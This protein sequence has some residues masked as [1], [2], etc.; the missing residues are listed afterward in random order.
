VSDEQETSVVFRTSQPDEAPVVAGRLLEAGIPFEVRVVVQAEREQ[1]ALAV[2]EAHMRSIGAAPHEDKPEAKEELDEL[3]PCPNCEAPGVRLRKPCAGCGYEILPA[4][5]PPV[6]V[7]EHTPGARTFCPECR[8][9]LTFPSG[10]CARCG[11]ELE[12]LESGDLLCPS[13]THVLYRDT[14]GGAVCKACRRVWI[15]LAG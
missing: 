8:D 2:I 15:E 6:P 3:L 12:P 7:K 9:P 11:E 1:E 5:A 14:V 4:E 10:A 13:L